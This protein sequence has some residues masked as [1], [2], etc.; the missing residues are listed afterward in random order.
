MGVLWV[1]NAIIALLSMYTIGGMIRGFSQEMF[2]LLFWCIGIIVGW[3]FSHNF[4]V[5]LIKFFSSPSIRLAGSLVALIIICL[6][7]GWI[8]KLLLGEAVKKTGLNVIDRLGGGLFGFTHGLAVVFV[9]VLIAG[10][11]PL[12]T[13]R[14]WH[15]SRYLPPFQTLA[16]LAKRNSSTKIAISLNYPAMDITD[17]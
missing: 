10:L 2:T 9:L 13:E 11:T 12:P 14:W 4:S 6:V 8:I 5:F 17:K 7:I 16:V 15:E 3:F 1:D